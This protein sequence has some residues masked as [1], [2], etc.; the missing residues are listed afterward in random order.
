MLKTSIMFFA[1]VGIEIAL[2]LKSIHEQ[3]VCQN[4]KNYVRIAEF[5]V[6]ASLALTSVIPWGFQWYLAAIYLAAR[7]VTALVSIIKRKE[8]SYR[9]KKLIFNTAGALILVFFALLPA[10]LFPEYHIIPVTG[11]YEVGTATYTYID[12][13]RI[14]TYTHGGWKRN[15]TVSFY[16]PQAMEGQCPLVVFS[17]GGMG[18]RASNTSLYHELAS[19]GYVVC[20]LDHTY[21]CLFSRD[22]GGHTTFISSDYMQDL[23]R[24]DTESNPEKSFEYYSEWMKIRMGDLDFVIN[25]ILAQAAVGNEDEVYKLVDGAKIAVMGHSLGGAAALGIGRARSD[26]KAVMALESPFMFDIIGVEKGEFIWNEADYPIAVLN[27]YS[28]SAWPLLDRR[29]QYAENYR[30][31]AAADADTFNAYIKGA[32]HFTLTDL[33]LRSP[34]LARILNGRA[35]TTET[36]Y[37]LKTVN[38]LALDFFDCYLKGEGPFACEAV[39]GN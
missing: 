2:A 32:G 22:A 38:R 6:F 26:I 28:D 16:Y 7:A 8:R 3:A 29:R 13:N 37:C 24:E 31:L 27:V 17:H 4:L 15:L 33:P 1:L 19:W 20:S 10:Y 9:A 35:A 34:L 25:Y 18:I 14:E 21:Q 36:E 39:Y 23:N 5:L 12:E 11:E 30:L